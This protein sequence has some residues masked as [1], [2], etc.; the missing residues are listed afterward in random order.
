MSTKPK[1][2]VRRIRQNTDIYEFSHLRHEMSDLGRLK[3]GKT[4]Y[5]M[6]GDEEMWEL[7]Y[8]PGS[9]EDNH[10]STIFVAKYL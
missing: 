9:V 7:A 10:S 5:L 2:I 8:K 6:T 3:I 4:A 1:K